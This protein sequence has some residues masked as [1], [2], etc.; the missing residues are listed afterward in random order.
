M[1]RLLLIALLGLLLNTNS[2]ASHLMGGELTAEY[3]GNNDYVVTLKLYRDMLGV[4][5]PTIGI[6]AVLDHN[7]ALVSNLNLP[8][9]TSYQMVGPYGVEVWCYSDTVT[10][11][12][13]IPSYTL[14][15]DN[16]CRNAAILNSAS[17]SS[18]SFFL[19]STFATFGTT[20]DNS[21][22][23]FLAPPVAFVPNNQAWQYNPLPFDADGDSLVW[24]IDTPMNAV[25][26]PIAGW[27][28]PFADPAGPFSI[29]SHTGEV[30]WT[31]NTLGNFVASFL[32]DEYRNG[33]RIGNM[34]RD[35]QLIV[36]ND[37]TSV[38]RLSN[39]NSTFP[40]H[41]NGY[42]TALL[43][44]GNMFSVTLQGTDTDLSDVLTIDAYGEPF[45]LNSN[46]ATFTS[47]S[48]SNGTVS[49]V[50]QWTPD[51]SQARPQPYIV[52]FRIN[53]GTWT[54]DETVLVNVGSAVSVNE[55]E[56]SPVG[57]VYPNPVSN[58]VF[59]PLELSETT[60]VAV[61]IYDLAGKKVL[62]FTENRYN[63]GTHL[64]GLNLDL[65]NGQYLISI[66]S[67]ER[68][69]SLQKIIVNK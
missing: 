37:T 16:C 69:L 3:I 19:S 10:L 27:V 14:T 13:S 64:I 21:T 62:S 68:V 50:F 5:A 44:P 56:V 65:G 25:N 46:P 45:I 1:K 7:G 9:D 63:R 30:T 59:V 49:G 60:N 58:R 28:T 4:P 52:V 24:S 67:G 61:N 51:A 8:V 18:E 15:Y 33:V 6:V 40:L 54:Y 11:S 35:M 34:R 36:V 17:P 41:P 42:N 2:N 12:S 57:P 39:F 47:T 32:I 26:V 43:P 66:D 53:D 23:V 38:P 22:P 31:P 48:S 20:A 55:T 29:N